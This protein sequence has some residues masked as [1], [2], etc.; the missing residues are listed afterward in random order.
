[1]VRT[2][3]FKVLAG[4]LASKGEYYEDAAYFIHECGFNRRTGNG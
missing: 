4:S 1:M 2:A 3:H